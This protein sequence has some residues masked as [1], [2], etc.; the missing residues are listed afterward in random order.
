MDLKRAEQHARF[1]MYKWGLKDWDFRFNTRCKRILGRC[2]FQ[3]ELI[4]LSAHY[5]E[6]N[7]EEE[8][9]D[10]IRHEIAHALAYINDGDAGHGPKWK[11]WCLKTGAS[12]E[13]IAT[14]VVM[15]ERKWQCCLVVKG[16]VVERLNWFAYRKSNISRRYM[17][18]RKEETLGRLQW[19]PIEG[20]E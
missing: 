20:G 14:D 17:R 12:P 9:L 7:T 3:K 5:V 2:F 6:L 8:V 11:E 19:L 4:E 10:T 15:P 13:R 18:G 16:V 1:E